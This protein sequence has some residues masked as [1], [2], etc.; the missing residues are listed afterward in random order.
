MARFL[1]NMIFKFESIKIDFN[2]INI[3]SNDLTNENFNQ[4]Y[5]QLEFIKLFLK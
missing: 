4:I 5:K 2:T 3:S 1:R